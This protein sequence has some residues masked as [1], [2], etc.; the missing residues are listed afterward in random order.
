MKEKIKKSLFH[1]FN[2][3]YSIWTIGCIY[4]T[5]NDLSELK[6]NLVDLLVPGTKIVSQKEEIAKIA[7]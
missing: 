2:I 6:I 3:L 1:I 4:L 7:M 5:I